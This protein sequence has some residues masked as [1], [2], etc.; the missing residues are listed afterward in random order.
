M[1]V[2]NTCEIKALRRRTSYRNAADLLAEILT[3]V[4]GGVRTRRDIEKAANL[5]FSQ[6]KEY[7]VSSIEIGMITREEEGKQSIYKITQKGVNFL[8]LYQE[9]CKMMQFYEL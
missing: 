1:V 4:L 8:R 3:V 5:S 9:Q 7:L 6:L 2:I